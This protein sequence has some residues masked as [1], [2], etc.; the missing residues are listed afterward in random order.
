MYYTCPQTFNDKWLVECFFYGKYIVMQSKQHFSL[1]AA[2]KSIF[3]LPDFTYHHWVNNI[4]RIVFPL[5]T[6]NLM[7]VTRSEAFKF[8]M[9]G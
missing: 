3:S 5:I 8:W 2:L 4:L 7:I 6:L 1:A 9:I